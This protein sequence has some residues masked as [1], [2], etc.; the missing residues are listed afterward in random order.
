M[1]GHKNLNPWDGMSESESVCQR[2]C[3]GNSSLNVVA[4]CKWLDRARLFSTGKCHDQ[5]EDL[6]L[7]LLGDVRS[8]QTKIT[9]MSYCYNLNSLYPP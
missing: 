7:L 9:N 6:I 4:S 1:A 8:P 5:A 3:S 2:K